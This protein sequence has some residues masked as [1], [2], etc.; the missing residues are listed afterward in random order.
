MAK[1]VVGGC[2]NSEDS[3][4][5]KLQKQP[6]HGGSRHKL[7]EAFPKCPKYP[8]LGYLGF[9]FGNR[10]YG[11]YLVL[12][13]LDSR[14]SLRMSIEVVVPVSGPNPRSAYHSFKYQN[15]FV[16]IVMSIQGLILRS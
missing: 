9:R 1:R 8:N 12:G 5:Q 6:E 11:R 13:Y 7:P 15:H 2:W 10:R 4:A 3:K 16:C 14:V